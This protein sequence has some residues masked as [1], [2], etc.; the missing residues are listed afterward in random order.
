VGERAS[1]L[2]LSLTFPHTSR[3]GARSCAK[4]TMRWPTSEQRNT[5]G[6]LALEIVTLTSS[7]LFAGA[8]LYISLVAHPARCALASALKNTLEAKKSDIKAALFEWND[9]Y[10]RAAPL[11]IFYAVVAGVGG[12]CNTFVLGKGEAWAWG[13][14]LMLANVPFTLLC[15]VPVNNELKARARAAADMNKTALMAH[16]TA[17]MEEPVVE[18]GE[19]E[20]GKGEPELQR[21]TT[22]FRSWS[23]TG[24]SFTQDLLEV[25]GNLHMVRTWLGLSG[26]LVLVSQL[27]AT[28]H[29]RKRNGLM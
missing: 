13:G 20:V 27:V 28:A 10:Q 4:K 25:W 17:G 21:T 8:A 18:E 7:A 11:Q 24:G 6:R 1:T 26:F 3:T 19:E 22:C 15:M 9:S 29:S 14:G 5:G 2:Y 16:R 12:L 23:L